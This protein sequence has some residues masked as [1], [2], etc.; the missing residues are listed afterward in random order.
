ME[1]FL[2]NEETNT[3]QLEKWEAA[4]PGLVA[5]FTTRW[6]GTSQDSFDSCNMGLHVGDVD[7]HVIQNRRRIADIQGFPFESWTCADQV[8]GNAVAK[9]TAGHKGAGRN[10]LKSVIKESDGLYTNEKGIFL[11]S[12]YADCV[13]LLFVDPHSKAVG[14]AHAGWKGSVSNIGKSMI[15]ALTGEYGTNPG[16]LLVAIGPSIGVCC[17]EV[18]ERVMAEVRK[19]TDDWEQV[20]TPSEQSDR[21]MLDLRLLNE[22]LLIDAGVD[23]A[24][25]SMTSYCTSCRNDI[26]FSHRSENGKTGRMASFIGWRE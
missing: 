2:L 5:G 25:I 24:H 16:Q 12:F 11:T 13:P 6:G 21:Y 1:P 20:A 18:D 17:Y 8:H 14:V 23:P 4:Y 22:R 15:T 26:F 7:E 19:A 10:D 9:V 3:L